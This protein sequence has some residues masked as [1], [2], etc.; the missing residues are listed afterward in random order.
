MKKL[1]KEFANTQHADEYRV[2]GELLTTY[3]HQVKR[4]MT[5]I[6]LPNFYDNEKP[7]KIALS[8][9]IGPSQ[10][11]Q[12][13]FKKY[14]KLKNAISY[15]K[16]QIKLTKD[17]IDYFEEIQTQIEL[18]EPQDLTDIQIELENGGYLRKNN[19]HKKN[20]RRVKINQ[21]E[22]FWAS[23]GTRIKVG[24]NNLQNEKLT[25]HSASKN[26][27]WLHVKNIP[28]SHVIVESSHPSDETLV[29]AAELAAY[30]SKSRNSANV[31][32][33]YVQVRR[34]R[35]PNGTKPGFVIYEGQKTLYVTPTE[36]KVNQLKTKNE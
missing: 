9:Q 19:H 17:E 29:E 3:L 6:T 34:I 10:N 8:N 26:D 21:P 15:L 33:D 24:K 35:K 2:K 14:Q 31:P 1:Q 28:G 23:D 13:Y 5:E 22:T 36:E 16:E 30:F 20:K 32:V 12:K 27:Y 25:L 11:A 7:L 4:G 18:A